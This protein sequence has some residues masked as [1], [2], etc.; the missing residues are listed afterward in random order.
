MMVGPEG[1]VPPGGMSGH[2]G[3]VQHVGSLGS[4]TMMQDVSTLL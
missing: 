1:V 2:S 3:I 4:G